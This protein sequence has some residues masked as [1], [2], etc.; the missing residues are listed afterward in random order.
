MPKRWSDGIGGKKAMF[1]WVFLLNNV[2]TSILNALTGFFIQT[3]EYPRN[4]VV[5]DAG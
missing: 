3:S 2:K 5:T 4:I 1:F